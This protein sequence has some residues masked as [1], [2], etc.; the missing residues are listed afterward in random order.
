MSNN[1]YYF[2]CDTECRGKCCIG[3]TYIEKEDI[4]FF[5]DKVPI[6]FEMRYL[7]NNYL[8][9]INKYKNFVKSIKQSSYKISNN[10]KTLYILTDI[11]IGSMKQNDKCFFLANDRLCK[12][13]DRKPLKCKLLPLSPLVPLEEMDKAFNQMKSYCI[14]FN[15]N[16]PLLWKNKQIYNKNFKKYYFEYFNK[17][18]EL[19][20]I[21]EINIAIIEQTTPYLIEEMF[22]NTHGTI[23]FPIFPIDEIFNEL[24]ISEYKKTFINNQIKAINNYFKI[25]KNTQND[26]ILKRQLIIY[27]G[28]KKQFSI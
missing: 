17:F 15:V 7:S 19:I 14:G 21:T 16:A 27:E 28:V 1:T 11:I 22:L 13:Q 9:Q 24:N 23:L 6:Y 2:K 20:P 18:K 25:Y 5:S 12:I 26:E 4:M 10:N 3:A 8:K